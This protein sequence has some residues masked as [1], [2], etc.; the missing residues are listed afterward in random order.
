MRATGWAMTAR[1]ERSAVDDEHVVGADAAG[2]VDLL[3]TLQ[4]AVVERSVGIDLASAIILDAALR[5]SGFEAQLSICLVSA[6]WL[7]R[8][9]R[10]LQ[11]RL[12]GLDANRHGGRSRGSVAELDHRW[13][14]Q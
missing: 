13:I 7:I 8:H 10:A 9:R 12:D 4:Q 2:D 14:G 5:R 1:W 6:S 11:R 3:E